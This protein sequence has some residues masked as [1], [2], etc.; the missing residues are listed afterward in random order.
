MCLQSSAGMKL[1]GMRIKYAATTKSEIALSFLRDM[2]ASLTQT[3]GTTR[4]LLFEYGLLRL[5]IVEA[6]HQATQ[7]LLELGCGLG[8]CARYTFR[9]RFVSLRALLQTR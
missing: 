7:S 1:N 3:R 4:W 6:R 5:T 8:A 2:Q 9:G